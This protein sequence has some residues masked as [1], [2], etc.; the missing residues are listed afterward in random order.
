MALHPQTLQ[1][2]LVQAAKLGGPHSFPLERLLSIC[3]ALLDV[4]GSSANGV[5]ELTS[6]D[7]LSADTF[8]QIRT[9]VSLRLL[10]QV[11]I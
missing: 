4:D 11:R 7:R 8:V 5:E 9:L 3:W 10:S 6:P 1:V 2:E